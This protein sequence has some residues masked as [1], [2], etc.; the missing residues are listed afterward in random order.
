M[1]PS[2]IPSSLAALAPPISLASFTACTLY[3]WSYLRAALNTSLFSWFYYEILEN[4]LSTFLYHTTPN[5]A[6]SIDITYIPIRH[7]FL[8]LTAV[9]DWYSRCIVG[10]EVDDTLD[11]RMVINALKSIC[12]VKTTDFEL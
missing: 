9:I 8:Y 12:C 2:G 11:T 1:V 5:Q 6:W 4:K 7:G 3:S 10:W